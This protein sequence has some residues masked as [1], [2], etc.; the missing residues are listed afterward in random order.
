METR[1]GLVVGATTSAMKRGATSEDEDDVYYHIGETKVRKGEREGWFVLKP[2][3]AKRHNGRFR[4]R[5][6]DL[7]I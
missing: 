6:Y 7:C 5:W 1:F 3:A 2:R 4:E